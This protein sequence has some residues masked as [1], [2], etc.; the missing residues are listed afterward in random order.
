MENKEE[1]K[2]REEA[3]DSGSKR[4]GR[5][6]KIILLVILGLMILVNGFLVYQLIEKRKKVEE[7]TQKLVS[8]EAL[9]DELEKE[10]TDYKEKIS[11]YKGEIASLDSVVEKKNA[12]LEERA[13]RIRTLVSKNKITVRKYN[14]ALEEL[15]KLRYYTQKY[16]RQIDSLYRENKRLKKQN[17]ALKGEVREKNRKVDNL[18]D[19]KVRLENKVSLGTRLKARSLNI[20]GI[21]IRN[22]GKEKETMNVNKIEQL[23]TCF[24]LKENII[25]DKG[26]RVLYVKII[27]P[28][29]ETLHI[30]SQGSGEFEFRGEKSH[31]TVKKTIMFNNKPDEQY[32]V[33]WAR[34]TEFQEGVYELKVFTESYLV[35][36]KRF[37]LEKGFSLF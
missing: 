1:H 13:K 14:E 24:S 19:D 26:K 11:G 37:E 20:T 29:G 8:S 21:K 22:N 7:T 16:S 30:E 36:E 28:N 12:I 18:K 33:Y 4:R 2:S 3:P 9:R 32:C 6:S 23:K 17:V 31:Y 34:G 25:A 5:K 35:G 27:D 15:E 10:I